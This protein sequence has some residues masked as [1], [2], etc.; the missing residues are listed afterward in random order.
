[1]KRFLVFPRTRIFMVQKLQKV[2]LFFICLYFRI[3]VSRKTTGL[4]F[5]NKVEFEPFIL[6]EA[7]F[8]SDWIHFD[9]CIRILVVRTSQKMLSW[10]IYFDFWTHVFR[11]LQFDDFHQGFSQIQ[12]TFKKGFDW[13]KFC[14]VPVIRMLLM[15]NFP[16]WSFFMIFLYFISCFLVSPGLISS[17][18]N[19]IETFTLVEEDSIFKTMHHDSWIL[20]TQNFQKMF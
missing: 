5:S 6:P 11:Y 8:F 20:R 7:E 2:L 18:R 14:F 1:M 17:I 10:L 19:P 13:E 3:H 12:C 15:R 4:I 9:P 16:K